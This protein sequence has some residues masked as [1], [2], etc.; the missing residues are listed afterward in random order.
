MNK[1]NEL[2]KSILNENTSY[3]I[4]IGSKV[5]ISG[6]TGKFSDKASV[7]DINKNKKDVKLIF[8]TEDNSKFI[9]YIP[10]KDFNK[11]LKTGEY[12]NSGQLDFKIL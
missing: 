2:Y 4:K 7:I 11:V 12:I 5:A 10:I 8:N 3:E 6:D 1:F 9:V